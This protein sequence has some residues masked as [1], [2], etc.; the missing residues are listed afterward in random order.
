MMDDS[1]LMCLESLLTSIFTLSIMIPNIEFD[2]FSP[3]SP[4][5]NLLF[6]DSL[7]FSLSSY[8]VMGMRGVFRRRGIWSSLCLSTYEVCNFSSCNWHIT[9]LGY[10]VK[11]TCIEGLVIGT[12]HTGKTYA[13]ALYYL[14]MLLTNPIFVCVLCVLSISTF[15]PDPLTHVLPCLISPSPSILPSPPPPSASA[16]RFMRTEWAL[17]T[18]CSRISR[19]AHN[20]A[21]LSA[22]PR[23]TAR[24][25]ML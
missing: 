16:S 12:E 6:F 25:S 19:D 8:K 10:N 5:L 13:T 4:N 7:S 9:R 3:P 23:I 18:A 17:Y 22:I 1:S 20:Y 14:A 2:L 15:L 21:A 24:H 11:V